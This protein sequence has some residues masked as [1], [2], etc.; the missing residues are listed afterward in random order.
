[1]AGRGVSIAIRFYSAVISPIRLSVR[2]GPV[3]NVIE[4]EELIGHVSR[5]LQS[6]INRLPENVNDLV[7][8]ASGSEWFLPSR[9]GFRL[10]H[11][12]AFSI[13]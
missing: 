8:E 1:M 6:Y 4:L 9:A 5:I 7:H 12:I 3:L 10:L 2:E 13:R 11:R